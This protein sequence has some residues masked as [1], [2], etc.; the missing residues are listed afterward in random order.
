MQTL[1]VALIVAA[2]FVYAAWLFLPKAGRRWLLDRLIAVSPA[3]LGARLVRI[4]EE[5]G[6]AG[7]STCKGCEEAPAASPPTRT[8]RI[9][10]H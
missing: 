8:I 3:P 6:A 5:P 9:H 7:C 4:R 1:I 2:A 10:R